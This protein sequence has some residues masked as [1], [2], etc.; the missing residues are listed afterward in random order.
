MPI[1]FGSINT[2]LPPN[3]VDQLIEAEKIPVK[4][5]QKLSLIHIYQQYRFLVKRWRS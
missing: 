2:G 5:M 3:I 1:S 4:N